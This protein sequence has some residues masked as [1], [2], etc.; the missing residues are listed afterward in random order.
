MPKS[1]QSWNS[2]W[3]LL[4]FFVKF[5][6][7]TLGSPGTF[8]RPKRHGRSLMA[9]FSRMA[10]QRSSSVSSNSRLFFRSGPNRM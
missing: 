7:I 10:V 5:T 1:S 6:R 3:S 8:Q 9:V 2:N 4:Y